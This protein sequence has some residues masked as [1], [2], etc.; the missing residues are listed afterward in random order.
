MLTK[1]FKIA[2]YCCKTQFMPSK[3]NYYYR[4]L[5]VAPSQWTPTFHSPQAE[6]DSDN[7]GLRWYSCL[8]RNHQ[9]IFA[10]WKMKLFWSFLFR[11]AAKLG[12]G[13][14]QAAICLT[15]AVPDLLS[16]SNQGRLVSARSAKQLMKD[17]W[18]QGAAW[19]NVLAAPSLPH[20]FN[21]LSLLDGM[22]LRLTTQRT[23][24]WEKQTLP[25]SSVATSPY[26]RTTDSTFPT[27]LLKTKNVKILNRECYTHWKFLLLFFQE[28]PLLQ[29][30]PPVL[31][32]GALMIKGTMF[33]FM[34][35]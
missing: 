6:M 21:F 25:W 7:T 22:P 9:G 8:P 13:D 4:N 12:P 15:P 18:G 23:A 11:L 30:E 24:F 35:L 34:N 5:H 19:M 10:Y 17:A 20:N 26:C 28:W 27:F 31:I 29:T 2:F 32:T 16:V 3:E 1:R 14:M 33:N